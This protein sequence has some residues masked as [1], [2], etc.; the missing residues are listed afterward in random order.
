M[1]RAHTQVWCPPIPELQ[2]D[3]NVGHSGPPSEWNHSF[4]QLLGVLAEDVSIQAS[5]RPSQVQDR[6]SHLG[7]AHIHNQPM[8]EDKG[9]AKEVIPEKSLHLQ[10]RQGACL[11]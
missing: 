1:G 4:S 11:C 8:M 9:L 2:L 10:S 5:Q 3:V 7:I 6:A